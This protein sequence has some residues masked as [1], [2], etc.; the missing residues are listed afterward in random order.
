[1]IFEVGAIGR[2]TPEN[3]LAAWVHAK[4]SLNLA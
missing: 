3:V 2:Y 1:M 4:S